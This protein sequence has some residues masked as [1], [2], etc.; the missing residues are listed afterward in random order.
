MTTAYVS[1]ANG[2]AASTAATAAGYDDEGNIAISAD[3]D[4]FI[5]S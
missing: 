5:Y 2:F 4:I 1:V 3:G